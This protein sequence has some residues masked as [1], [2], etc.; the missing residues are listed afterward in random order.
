MRGEGSAKSWPAGAAAPPFIRFGMRL[1]DGQ[2]SIMPTP[3]N[4]PMVDSPASHPIPLLHREFLVC[5]VGRR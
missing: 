4:D 1:E 2:A 5:H 3:T